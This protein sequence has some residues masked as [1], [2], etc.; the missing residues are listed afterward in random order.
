MKSIQCIIVQ[1]NENNNRNNKTKKKRRKMKYV[2]C[3]YI[4]RHSTQDG[5]NK[6][7]VK[8]KI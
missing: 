7:E 6:N 8:R 2:L 3:M 1:T 5:S 4:V